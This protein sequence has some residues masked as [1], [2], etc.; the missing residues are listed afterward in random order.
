MAQTN[1]NIVDIST[2]FQAVSENIRTGTLKV[3]TADSKCLIYFNQG[4]IQ[5]CYSLFHSSFLGEALQRANAVTASELQRLLFLQRDTKKSM[6]L[7]L[8]EEG[9]ADFTYIR[10]LCE[11]QIAEDI[12][13]IFRWDNPSCEFF[14]NEA[15][16]EVFDPELLHLGIMMSPSSLMM[17]AARRFDI[18]EMIRQYVPS[19]LDIPY[20][21][22]GSFPPVKDE[23]RLL[24]NA[25]DGFNDIEEILAKI[26]MSRFTAMEY[27]KNF[28]EEGR[29]QLKKVPQLLEMAHSPALAEQMHK[30]I[31]LYERIE[32][33]GDKN[34]ETIHWLAQ[35]YETS[36]QE[37]KAL[38]KYGELGKKAQEEQNIPLAAQAYEKVIELNS[39]SLPAY[40]KLI[41]LLYALDRPSEAAEKSNL[42][43][44][45]LKSQNKK[46]AIEILLEA[47]KTDEDNV[48]NLELLATLYFDMGERID[49]LLTYE[50]L[51]EK[52]QSLGNIDKSLQIYHKMLEI[53]DENLEAHLNLANILTYC[54]RTDEAVQQYKKLAD[55][56]NSTG[57][58]KNSFTC[59]YLIN[60]CNKIMEF[61]PNNFSAREW[62]VD[63]YI[64]KKEHNKA[65][66]MLEEIFQLLQTREEPYS[67]IVNLKKYIKL[68]SDAFEKRRELASLYGKIGE[69]DE[70]RQEYLAL[71]KDATELQNYPIAQ[72]A[73]S[74]LL[75]L[76]PFCLEA[77]QKLAEVLALQNCKQEAADCYRMLGYFYKGIAKYKDSVIA[78]QNALKLAP[79]EQVYCQ[80]EMADNY[81]KLDLKDH[82]I[83][84]LQ[85]YAATSYSL[86]NYGD[87][88]K[89]CRRI[90]NL[91]PDEPWALDLMTKLGQLGQT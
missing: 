87:A 78:F 18:W 31:R 19:P 12:C 55:K 48:D 5:M 75:V 91:H 33:L 26:H 25:V 30:Q 45:K 61:E 83:A 71:C 28:V 6:V 70:S 89:A 51:A 46:R 40:E 35:A 57:V 80:Y 10:Q 66:E 17:E 81:Q 52:Y 49:A 3:S 44:K 64:F 8:Q 13:E 20:L 15:N 86:K 9:I 62:L 43:A 1:L 90:L 88:S 21:S 2:V 76:N 65:I 82:A 50:K 85:K 23:P 11:F 29:L 53:D 38:N 60:V 54:N 4:Y 42:Y 59:L 74:E 22:R 67:Q 27:L 69:I 16:P 37:D 79:K 68:K 47:N 36:F 14:E 34:I 63:A 32:S 73:L 7:L 84:A 72:K 58:I 77:H 24:L 39:D 56:L 41:S